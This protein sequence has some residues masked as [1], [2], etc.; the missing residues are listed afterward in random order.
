MLQPSRVN[1]NKDEQTMTIKF[2]NAIQPGIARLNI[3]F[4]GILNDKLVGFYRSTYIIN[5]EK[6]TMATTQFEATH[7]R[8]AFPCWDEPALKATFDVIL[9]VPKDRTAL[10]N[11]D[12][13]REIEIGSIL[14]E[15][16]YAT[17]PKMSTYLLAFIVGE[18]DYVQ[19]LTDDRK[20]MVRVFTPRT[21]RD[22]GLFA[23]DVAVKCLQY[24]RDYF[25]VAYPLPKLGSKKFLFTILKL[26][27]FK[28]WLA[29]LISLLGQW[30]T[31]V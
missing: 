24:Y 8:Q 18:L 10:S 11:M 21:K 20:V 9:I 27:S 7:A 29:F 6:R 15:V 19:Q 17:T 2:R 5:G 28:T 14:R 4:S 12:P 23:L 13:I 30:K 3:T 25:G 16:H 22:S 1:L 26:L 31:G